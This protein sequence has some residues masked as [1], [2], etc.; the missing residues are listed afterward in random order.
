[1]GARLPLLP[2]ETICPAGILL[3]E[4]GET[5]VGYAFRSYRPGDA[6]AVSSV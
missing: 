1:M 2:S 3:K 6:C 5:P 4:I